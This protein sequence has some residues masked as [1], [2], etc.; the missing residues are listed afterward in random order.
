MSPELIN[1][2]KERIVSGRTKADIQH[3]VL[4]M[5]YTEELF[6]AAYTLANHDVSSAPSAGT[7]TSIHTL[8]KEAYALSVEKWGMTVLIGIP[9]V[10]LSVFAELNLRF[11]DDL[12]MTGLFS[13]LSIVVMLIYLIN[14]MVV[15]FLVSQGCELKSTTYRDGFRW[16]KKHFFSILF[17]YLLMVFA[18]WGG[19]ILLIIPGCIM[20]ITL[21][22]SQYVFVLEEKRGMAALLRS[23]ALVK[24]RWFTVLKKVI[25]LTLYFLIPV[26]I[27][28]VALEIV[29][30]LYP[31][32]DWRLL[33]EIILQI[34]AAFFAVISMHVMFRIYRELAATVPDEPAS[35]SV[36]SR[37]WF[38]VIVGVLIIPAV[39]AA[40][41]L[42]GDTGDIKDAVPLPLQ[43][44]DTPEQLLPL[45]ALADEYQ[46]TH[47]SFAGVCENLRAS[48]EAIECNDSESAWALSVSRGE[49]SWCVDSGHASPKR[50]YAALEGNTNCITIDSSE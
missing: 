34:A 30:S 23:R 8:V 44:T 6:E 25:G 20:M 19:L 39:I 15:L 43:S 10:L 40:A 42:F 18:V 33:G 4:S 48:V 41:Y 12:M 17:V 7:I 38:A 24:G 29:D 47:G 50:I 1:A 27:V 28:T 46:T 45:F 9:M 11:E 32:S 26:F 35:K 21:Y 2:I 49:Q 36:A 37:H 16:A 13:G 5:G 3:E 22:F 31:I 14:I